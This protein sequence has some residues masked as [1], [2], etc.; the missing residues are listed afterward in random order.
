MSCDAKLLLAKEPITKKTDINTLLEDS[1]EVELGS[2]NP[3]CAKY[4]GDKSGTCEAVIEAKNIYIRYAHNTQNG[5]VTIEDKV[6][7]QSTWHSWTNQHEITKSGYI[8]IDGWLTNTS[9]GVGGNKRGFQVEF[10][11][12]ALPSDWQ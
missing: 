4:E 11:C 7:G 5:N 3:S 2:I 12:R 1:T 10:T 8:R 6:T 9:G